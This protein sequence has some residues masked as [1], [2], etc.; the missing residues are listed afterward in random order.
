[1][2]RTRSIFALSPLFILF[3]NLNILDIH[4]AVIL[5]ITTVAGP[6]IHWHWNSSFKI[7]VPTAKRLSVV[8]QGICKRWSS[9]SKSQSDYALM[10]NGFGYAAVCAPT[11]AAITPALSQCCLHYAGRSPVMPLTHHLH[12]SPQSA[13]DFDASRREIQWRDELSIPR[14]LEIHY[15]MCLQ[16]SHGTGDQGNSKT[17]CNKA[18]R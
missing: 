18:K 15:P 2:L 14:D 7:D 12:K 16:A 11:G 5:Y 1:V 10:L 13:A 3:V 9:W 8:Q 6:D 4:F 17:G